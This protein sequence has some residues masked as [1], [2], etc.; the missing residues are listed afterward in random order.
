MEA[1]RPTPVDLSKFA[2]GQSR[3]S[4]VEQVGTPSGTTREADGAS[5]DSYE[6]YTH[7]Y[8]AGGKIP[9]A[10]LEGAADAFT[11]GLAEVVSTPLEGATKN[12]LHPVSICYVD[13]KLVRVTDT[14][15]VVVSSGSAAAS[16][17]AKGSQPVASSPQ[18]FE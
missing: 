18:K 9:V 14:G 1:T 4:I 3:D 16:E 5:C 6:L 17:P 15:N 7:G 8:G 11:L 13:G 10:F 2:P 12:E